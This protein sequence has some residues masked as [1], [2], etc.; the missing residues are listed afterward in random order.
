MEKLSFLKK[1][2]TTQ[3]TLE[4]SKDF[5][6]AKYNLIRAFSARNILGVKRPAKAAYNVGICIAE[7]GG[8]SN[9]RFLG[10]LGSIFDG[11]FSAKAAL[12]RGFSEP[13]NG[14]AFRKAVSYCVLVKCIVY[15]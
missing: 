6:E 3:K 10:D 1:K 11:S 7:N 5:Q 14:I 8:P 13:G 4:L 15:K 12:K 9:D 2:E